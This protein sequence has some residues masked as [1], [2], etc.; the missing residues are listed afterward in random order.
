MASRAEPEEW[1]SY[2]SERFYD[3]ILE[4]KKVGVPLVKINLEM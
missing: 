4:C 3:F 1:N 2:D